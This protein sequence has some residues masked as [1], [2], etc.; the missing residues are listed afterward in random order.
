MWCMVREGD[1]VSS[2]LR[3]GVVEYLVLA[4]VRAQPRY[5]Q[6]LVR[7][8]ATARELGVSEGTV[9]P[10]LGRLRRMG[11]VNTEWRES[12]QGPPRRYYKLTD[13]GVVALEAFAVQWTSFSDA[14]D[15]I[16]GADGL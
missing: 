5:G 15:D 10:L 9:Y 2:Q 6:E 3:R 16:L 1:R 14:V 13:E 12:T 11:W 8:L 7:S 4:L